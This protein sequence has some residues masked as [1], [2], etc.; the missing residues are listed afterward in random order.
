MKTTHG[1][2]L[3]A[4]EGKRLLPFTE[5]EPKCFVQIAGVTIL[6]NALNHF[7]LHGV[8]RVS[9]VVGHLKENIQ[10]KIGKSY[11]GMTV[12]YIHNS[13]FRSTNS[14]FS[15][16]LALREVHEPVW[17]LEGD[18]FFDDSVLD[19]KVAG[20]FA[21]YADSSIRDIDGAYLQSGEDGVVKSLEIIRDLGLLRDGHHKSMGLL[22]LTAVGAKKMTDWLSAGVQEDKVNLYYDLIVAEHLREF[23]VNLVDVRGNKWFEIDTYDDLQKAQNLFGS[24][25]R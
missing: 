23:K 4:G 20:D 21:W 19:L 14:M 15:L 3:A 25:G 12:E 2:I 10:D 11:R 24:H 22:H 5:Q 9:I 6:E 7:A 8:I 17:V 13:N 18:V 1:I 16:Y